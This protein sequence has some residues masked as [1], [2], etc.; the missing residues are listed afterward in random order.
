MALLKE[1]HPEIFNSI[2]RDKDYDFDID[3][4]STM[5]AKKVY[6]ICENGHE[7]HTSVSHIV[8]GNKCMQC[9]YPI[10][11][12]GYSYVA[13]YLTDQ[14]Q[15]EE[16][17]KEKQGSTK[18]YSFTCPF[19]FSKKR[20]RVSTA[21]NT[22]EEGKPLVNAV[23][24]V[25]LPK[26]YMIDDYDYPELIPKFSKKVFPWR[27]KL[28]HTWESQAGNL[29]GRN[30]FCPYCEN[31]EILVGFNDLLTFA[32]KIQEWLPN[33]DASKILMMQHCQ[34]E[35]TCPECDNTFVY[36]FHRNYNKKGIRNTPVCPKCDYGMEIR[37]KTLK[38]ISPIAYRWYSPNNP[39]SADEIKLR[40][41][42]KREFI[43]DE[44]H[45]FKKRI[46]TIKYRQGISCPHCR[47]TS[48]EVWLKDI[49]VENYDGQISYNDRSILPDGKEFDIYLPEKKI[50]FEFNG[51]FWHS[52]YYLKDTKYHYKKWKNAHD[53][54]IQLITIWEDYFYSKK[55]LIEDMILYK[56]GLH[57]E[58]KIYARNT[59]VQEIAYSEAKEYL[60]KYHIQGS[61][62]GTLYLGLFHQDNLVA[63]S[64]WKKLK[65]ELF[66]E[67]YAS[68]KHVVG[69]LGK[70]IKHIERYTD[71]PNMCDCI[72]TFSDNSVSDGAMY[73]KLGFVKEKDIAP[74]YKYL[75]KNSREHK[76]KYRKN[77][78]K[79]DPE[80]LYDPSFTEK[81]LA[82][83]NGLHRIWDCGKIKWCYYF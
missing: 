51:I 1:T 49:I 68:D 13:D 2:L 6:I 36:N 4:L 34:Q 10:V 54:G 72:S 25:E 29:L 62:N 55:E 79:T 33:V 21:L 3:K 11:E 32:P 60:D 74:D 82:D 9:T 31:R 50:A 41:S 42:L 45:I 80:L 30:R 59:T 81:Q 53:K 78:F 65:Q 22:I 26:E 56:L 43:C 63:V 69:G 12:E 27:C 8:R 67:R 38:E 71:Y 46:D 39:E 5:S 35:V 17:L 57:K 66:L 58:D 83:L 76:F 14:E 44:G 23:N 20:L 47:S 40:K 73:K 52:E 61:C 16:F 77:R 75:V 18:S 28:G 7:R 24:Y 64:V 19:T 70:T 48:G 37:E 15:R